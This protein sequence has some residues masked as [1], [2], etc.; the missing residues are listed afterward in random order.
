VGEDRRIGQNGWNQYDFAL[1]PTVTWMMRTN[2]NPVTI[3]TTAE[4]SDVLSTVYGVFITGDTVDDR[5]DSCRLDNPMIRYPHIAY[6]LCLA[7]HPS[8][9]HDADTLKSTTHPN[10]SPVRPI[11]MLLQSALVLHHAG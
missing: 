4:M 2:G 7:L 6:S 10:A 11:R 5:K 3:A 9:E 8:S 1:D